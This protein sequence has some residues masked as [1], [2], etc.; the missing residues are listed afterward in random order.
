MTDIVTDSGDSLSHTVPFHEGY[1]LHHAILRVA[2]LDPA[3]YLM[4]ILTE[5]GYTFTAAAETEIVWDVTEKLCYNGVVYDTKLKST[6]E[7]DKKKTFELQDGNFVT[8]GAE[9]FRFAKVLFQPSFSSKE[10]RRIPRHF[11]PLL[12]EV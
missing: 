8:V 11:F 9:R 5:Q 7:T 4:K 2:G 6:S 3:E 1:A 12:H 10:A